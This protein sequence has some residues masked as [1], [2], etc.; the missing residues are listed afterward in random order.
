MSLLSPSSTP[1]SSKALLALTAV[2][3][4]GWRPPLFH[5]SAPAVALAR[6]TTY[7][8]LKLSEGTRVNKNRN[9]EW[10][11]CWRLRISSAPTY[12]VLSTNSAL[13]AADSL[14]APR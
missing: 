4:Q 9:L 12:F 8:H 7:L 2:L 5:S 14:N 10:N 11:L 13:C 1:V 3:G 6:V